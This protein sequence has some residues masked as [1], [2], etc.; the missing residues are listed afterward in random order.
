ME[1]FATPF[2]HSIL[3]DEMAKKKKDSTEARFNLHGIEHEETAV[4]PYVEAS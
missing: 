4:F 2:F 1:V 3:E